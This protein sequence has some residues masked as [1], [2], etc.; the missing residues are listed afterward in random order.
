MPA[1]TLRVTLRPVNLFD[2]N[3]AVD[4]PPSRQEVNCSVGLNGLGAAGPGGETPGL[5]LRGGGS[6]VDDGGQACSS[7]AS[8]EQA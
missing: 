3:P 5:P 4:V 2:R 7:R 8:H 1:E 6:D